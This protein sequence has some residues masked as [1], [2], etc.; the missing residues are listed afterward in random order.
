MNDRRAQYIALGGLL[1]QLCAFT[2]LLTISLWSSSDAINA[3]A[4][5][6]LFGVPI[7]FLTFLVF[8]Q[9]SRVNAEA[10]ETAELR[11]QRE[12][13]GSE[14]LFELDD[15]ALLLEQNRLR[16][17]VRWMF[18]GVTALLVAL[19]LGG[20]FVGWSWTFDQAF[21]R[22]GEHV[23]RRAEN[24][25][26][27]MWFV[28]FTGFLCFLYARY[29]LTLSRMAE[30]RLLRAGATS[31][32]GVAMACLLLVIALMAGGHL[33][34][35][36]PLVAYVV[37]V[38]LVV[39]GIELAANLI[40]D[41]YRPRAPEAIPRPAFESRLLGLIGEPG[42]VAHSIAEAINYQFGFE[43]S[44]TWFY[45]LLQRWLFPLMVA[46]CILVLALSGVV[47]IHADEQAYVERFG[48]PVGDPPR[49]LSP[50]L[51][52]KWP[53]PVDV[54]R[55]AP[56]K[57]V[58]EVVVGEAT[59]EEDPDPRRAIV[60]TQEHDFVPELML[61]VAS[62]RLGMKDE[63]SAAPSTPLSSDAAESVAV[64]LLMV[65]VPVNYRVKD[66]RK[67]LY[68]Y[69]DPVKVM[70]SVA[71]QYLC[72]Y[73][74]G[75][76]IDELMGPG[77][78]RFN[79]ELK[80]RVQARM[81]DLDLGIEVVFAGIRSAHPPTKE[82]VADAFQSVVAAQTEMAATINAALGE[83]QKKLTAVAGTETRARELDEAIRRRERVRS[84]PS[85]VA[86]ARV[87][88]NARVEELLAGNPSAGILPLSGKAAAVIADAR[89]QASRMVADAAA[90]VRVFGTEVAAYLAAPSLYRERK[91]LEI[92]EDLDTV[93]KFLIVGDPR[94]VIVEYRTTE[95][96]GLDRVLS[97]GARLKKQ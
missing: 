9:I 80:Q 46:T 85:A 30:W 3:V 69:S 87:R 61:L 7:W 42:G 49:L 23:V 14:A 17:M 83:A 28:V 18:P 56:V 53:Y 41:F 40:L 15:E 64:S 91:L 27:M 82:R 95:E 55:R 92:Y 48:R 51:H 25:T 12:S 71:Y 89:A 19:L 1:L 97:E 77:R 81:D 21:N 75:V 74:A 90:K 4:R 79:H 94:T 10:L 50:G 58:Q 47:I 67:F 6:A 66:L 65:S 29:S 31:L 78:D 84:D 54:V 13:G 60:W 16:W 63:T 93:R 59:A 34:W 86:E 73:A 70:E 35:F 8:K 57:R 36:E 39:L 68:G 20:H 37:R 62:P 26:L 32:A 38:A 44:S 43:V 76:D 24:P 72:E 22:T 45:Q 2:V 52:L 88:A 33:E 96:G 11:R 5:L